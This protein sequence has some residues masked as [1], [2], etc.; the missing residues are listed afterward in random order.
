MPPT[1]C[2][3]TIAM[4]ALV[5]QTVYPFKPHAAVAPISRRSVFEA[6]ASILTAAVGLGGS[7]ILPGTAKASEPPRSDPSRRQRAAFEIRQ[8]AAQTYR[9]ASRPVHISNGDEA[10]YAD[11]RASFAKTLPH[12]EAGEVDGDAFATFVSVLSSGDPDGFE[13]IPRDPN[14]AVDLN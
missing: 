4:E 12:N 7:A 8:S 3:C 1:C 10:R 5:R 11:K 14:A 2:K 9:D 6:G 13:T